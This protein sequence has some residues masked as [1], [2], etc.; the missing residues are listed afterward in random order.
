[1]PHLP[2]VH[3]RAV[4]GV[5]ADAWTI[6]PRLWQRVSMLDELEECLEL[7]LHP[8]DMAL[9]HGLLLDSPAWG[10]GLQCPCRSLLRSLLGVP[11]LERPP[12]YITPSPHLD[13]LH[14]TYHCQKLVSWSSCGGA[15]ETNPTRRH[16][17]VGSMSDLTQWVKDLVLL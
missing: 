17:V 15:A 6:W 14:G 3:E 10:P 7:S 2:V 4:L 11:S 9:R 12:S 16:E 5:G 1:M 13:A 8:C